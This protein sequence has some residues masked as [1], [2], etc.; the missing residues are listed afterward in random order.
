MVRWYLENAALAELHALE[1]NFHVPLSESTVE[2]WLV[3]ADTLC[4]I[5][6]MYELSSKRSPNSWTPSSI[7]GVPCWRT[8]P[9]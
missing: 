5:V 9:L 4:M 6:V 1:H 8:A 2:M 7:C 3:D